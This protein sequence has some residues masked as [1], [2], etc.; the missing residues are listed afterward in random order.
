MAKKVIFVDDSATVLMSVDMA[1][2]DL[3]AAGVIEVETYNN[4][5]TLIEDVKN[6]KDYDLIV[7]DINMPQLNGFELTVELKKLRKSKPI[8]AL[9][10][11]NTSEMKIKGK[12]AGIIG[13]ITK[14]FSEGKV[15]MAIKRV[16]RIR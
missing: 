8:I 2:Q 10:T 5:E 1:T 4:P 11:E 7:T 16:L 12:E 3:V 14:P 15:I 13:W 6:G 9:T